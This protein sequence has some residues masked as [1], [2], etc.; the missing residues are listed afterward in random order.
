MS[1]D[2]AC[3]GKGHY[4]QGVQFYTDRRNDRAGADAQVKFL[5]EAIPARGWL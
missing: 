4:E 2:R 1:I 5:L 3:F